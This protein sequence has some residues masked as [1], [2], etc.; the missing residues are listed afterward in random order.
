M[1]R[2][3]RG[4]NVRLPYVAVAF[5]AFVTKQGSVLTDD[6]LAPL[7]PDSSKLEGF[8]KDHQLNQIFPSP[9]NQVRS[10]SPIPY[11]IFALFTEAYF[12]SRL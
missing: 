9:P 11:T 2:L 6:V 1:K 12:L 3:R 4:Q 10:F 5:N 7:W 8:L